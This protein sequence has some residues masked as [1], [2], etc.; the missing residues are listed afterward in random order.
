MLRLNKIK[1]IPIIF[2]Q[3]YL[4]F[5]VLLFVF[6][7]WN[8]KLK[9]YP[10]LITLL[11]IY[12]GFMFIGYFVGINTIKLK[13]KTF[14]IDYCKILKLVKPL[15]IIY[16][17]VMTLDITRSLGLQSIS[18]KGIIEKF[19]IG[20]NEPSTAYYAKAQI[21]E[22]NVY[23]GKIGTI[24]ISIFSIVSYGMIP[25]II[26]YYKT[27]TMKWKL[28]S[29]FA[30]LLQV[31]KYVGTG[32]NKGIFDIF[33]FFMVYLLINNMQNRIGNIKNKKIKKLKTNNKKMY[34]IIFI[35]LIILLS[36][37][38]KF[39]GSRSFGANLSQN[40]TIGGIVTLKEDEQ[41]IVNHMPNGLKKPTILL[42]SYLCQGYYG[43]GLSLDID[44][45]DYMMG[46]GNSL[47]LVDQLDLNEYTLQKKVE[48]KFGW[49]SRVQW[50]SMYSWIA[51]DLGFLGVALFMFL[52]GMFTAITYKDSIL[53]NDILSKILFNFCIIQVL[54]I[55]AN[56][57]MTSNINS[58]L[59]FT[60]FFLIWVL[61]KFNK[62]R[63]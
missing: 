10:M 6:G 47:F 15:I 61:Y 49:D 37:F 46:V 26:N 50:F 51:N 18:I 3:I 7:P 11:I 42:S 24:I 28:I 14:D 16:I 56:S 53:N 19:M 38:T 62:R 57:Q 33:I 43:L 12:Q 45:K 9:N 35:C 27:F 25:I 60:F 4:T 1:A 30:I 29:L 39:I 58:T 13:N 59:S 54:F 41:N 36:T 48:D 20:L 22:S 55:P 32:T 5:T 44:E 17:L 31:V 34:L 23:L 63:A 52:F 40:T 2:I 8:F 21:N